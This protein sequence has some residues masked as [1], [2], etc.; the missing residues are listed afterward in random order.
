MGQRSS[1]M[2]NPTYGRRRASQAEPVPDPY[3]QPDQDEFEAEYGSNIESESTQP[4][5]E[6]GPYPFEFFNKINTELVRL[7]TAQL[8]FAKAKPFPVGP[9]TAEVKCRY[10]G[11]RDSVKNIKYH[12]ELCRPPVCPECGW[13]Y[14][15]PPDFDHKRCTKCPKVYSAKPGDKMY[16]FLEG[17]IPR[18]DQ[19]SVYLPHVTD[20]EGNSHDCKVEALRKRMVV[21]QKHRACDDMAGILT[22][23]H[24]MRLKSKPPPWLLHAEADWFN[25]DV[26]CRC[27]AAVDVR[28]EVAQARMARAALD[29][30]QKLS[31]LKAF[32]GN[33][34][35][36]AESSIETDELC[37]ALRDALR[38]GVDAQ[39]IIENGIVFLTDA[40]AFDLRKATRLAAAP[41]ELCAREPPPP[42]WGVGSTDPKPGARRCWWR[43]EEHS[44]AVIA[45]KRLKDILEVA[46]QALDLQRVENERHRREQAR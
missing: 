10:C 43:M 7:D 30:R 39:Y 18:K 16:P 2:W 17:E 45:R 19:E 6:P 25:L 40:L 23:Y 28:R 32:R 33:D 3:W 21:A 26:Q 34:T 38:Y 44:N 9:L 8:H 22:E 4:L 29:A 15:P 46:Y 37:D 36:S 41:I 1:E 14:K 35:R 20:V 11:K 27:R 5:E 13:Q 42:R 12:Q 31:C 24:D